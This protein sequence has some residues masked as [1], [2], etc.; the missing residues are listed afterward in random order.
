M[1]NMD[2][3]IDNYLSNI[4]Y[5]T[6]EPSSFYGAVK[7][8]H[9]I[10]DRPDK[11][12]HVTYDT[13]KEWLDKQT[14]HTIHTTPPG[15]F[16][17][18]KIIVEHLDMQ[19]DSDLL[20]FADFAKYNRGYKYLVVCIDLFSRYLWV[21]ALKT[22]AS[23][24]TA[25]AC[26]AI[27]D[28]GRHPSVLRTDQGREYLGA[29]FQDL[30]KDYGV[31]HMLAYGPHKASYAERV[32]RTIED[33]LYKYFYE[34]QTFNFIDII[35]SIV[36]SYNNTIHSSINMPPAKVNE[37][38]SRALYERVYIPILNKRA[39]HP[40]HFSFL[41]GDFVRLS[42]VDTPF[43]RGYQ[44]QWTEEI[45][46]V[47][48]RIPSHPPRYKVKDLTGDVIKGSFYQQELQ[49]VHVKDPDDIVYKI[50]RV[51]STKTVKGQKLSLVKWYGYSDKFN[52]YVPTSQ[53]S[54]YT[55]K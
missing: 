27:F 11:P 38:N 42:R 28:E 31:T 43:K 53:I 49:K 48:N 36:H 45:F 22:K 50:D 13:V 2:E 10:K 52:S 3:E 5:D 15:K 29:P 24:E 19:W 54:T 30:L 41:N 18:E 20:Q 37:S 23:A 25:K 35:D 46:Q 51:I 4:Y 12:E 8:W 21:K 47:Y 6:N 26:K 34:K 16:P 1:K 17:T 14:T 55:G 39:A 7:L 9:H 44:E 40:V 33:R 32:N